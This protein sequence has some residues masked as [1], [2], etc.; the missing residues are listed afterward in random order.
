[1]LAICGLSSS[2]RTGRS[3]IGSPATGISAL[4][5]AAEGGRERVAAGPRAG[6][7]DRADLA[8][9]NQLTTFSPRK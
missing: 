2:A 9:D 8:H 4:I 7:D 1:M 5:T 6:Q 3:T